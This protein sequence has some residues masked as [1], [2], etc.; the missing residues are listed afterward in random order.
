MGGPYEG[1][2][3]SYG[4][5]YDTEYLKGLLKKSDLDKKTKYLIK[6]TL[7]KT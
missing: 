4:T 5:L 1:Q 6:K 3:L 7:A 2:E